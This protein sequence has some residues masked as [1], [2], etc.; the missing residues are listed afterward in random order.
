MEYFDEEHAE[1]VPVQSLERPCG[2]V[3]HSS[4]CEVRKVFSYIT[5]IYTNLHALSQNCVWSAIEQS[6]ACQT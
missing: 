4:M 3:H 5:Q 6:V 1:H 2:E